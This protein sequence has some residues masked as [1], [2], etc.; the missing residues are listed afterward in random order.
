MTSMPETP[1]LPRVLLTAFDAYR[2]GA[3]VFNE[4]ASR[5]ALEQVIL[6]PP[7]GV[8][9]ATRIYPVDFSS[10]RKRI[11][12]DVSLGFDCV[13]LTGQAPSSRSVR[14]EMQSRNLGVDPNG[15]GQKF[16]LA[17]D[18]PVELAAT[19]DW[20]K[21]LGNPPSSGED[22][23]LSQD[24]GSFLC[25]AALYF[26]ILAARR[27]ME[28]GIREV[29]SKV[30]FVHVPL[31]PQQVN[32]GSPCLPTERTAMLLRQLIEQAAAI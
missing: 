28:A 13:I 17:S 22:V 1:R 20:P 19:I 11:E 25:N 12:E 2:D 23:A 32:F 31:S 7:R 8:M 24:A 18:G 29:A 14:L 15:S 6:Q 10:I 27:R 16:V 4:N 9:L 5:S 3:N 26:A 21:M 30:G